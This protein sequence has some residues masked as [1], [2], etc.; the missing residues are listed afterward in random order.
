MCMLFMFCLWRYMF[1]SGRGTMVNTMGVSFC[2]NEYWHYSAVS[3]FFVCDIQFRYHFWASTPLLQVI[4]FQYMFKVLLHIWGCCS[5]VPVVFPKG[6]FRPYATRLGQSIYV[7]KDLNEFNVIMY[8]CGLRVS[9]PRCYLCI[10]K[11]RYVVSS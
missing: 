1:I 7:C 11:G 10:F 8:L 6:M 3:F 2:S 5:G 4:S 9:T